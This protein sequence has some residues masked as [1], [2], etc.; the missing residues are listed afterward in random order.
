LLALD[1]AVDTGHYTIAIGQHAL[2]A[3]TS[4]DRNIAIGYNAGVGLTSS[5][6]CTFVGYQAGEDAD[7]LGSTP[8]GCTYIG[9]YSGKNLDD[10]TFNTAVGFNAMLGSAGG[11]TCNDNVAIGKDAMAAIT[12][13]DNN[14]V[15]GSQAGVALTTGNDNVIIGQSAGDATTDTSGSV[16]I[17]M[18]AGGTMTSGNANTFIGYNAGA[19]DATM[20]GDGNVAIGYNTTKTLTSGYSNVTMGRSA[21]QYLTTGHSNVFIGVGSGGASSTTATT[22]HS[23]V[24]IGNVAGAQGR[25]GFADNVLVGRSAGDAITTGQNNIMIGKEAGTTGSPGGNFTTQSS[26]IVIGDENC[27]ASHIQTDWTV[28]SD[29]RDKTDVKKLNLGLDFINKLFP[30]TYYWDKR[31]KYIDRHDPNANLNDVTTDGTHKEDQMDVGFLAQDVA[32][33]E[34]SYGYK[35][36]DKTN[37][38]T[39]LSEDGKMYGT[40]YNKFVPMLV[41]AVQELSA[42]VEEQA[43]RIEEL[44][45]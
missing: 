25:S 23:N 15:I 17:G 33:I 35:I 42:K 21:G 31:S 44:E 14:T 22:G 13:G 40:K 45:G 30:V 39:S 4:G 34:S 43:K 38:T 10:G 32:E 27:G 5:N 16:I 41:K 28:A 3:L 11:S 36:E 24:C 37:L 1:A 18:A 26:I 19:N 29:K 12:I 7:S 2:G 8:A 6:D 9:S 20:T